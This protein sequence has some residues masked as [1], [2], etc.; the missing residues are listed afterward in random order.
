LEGLALMGRPRRG[1]LK[2]RP[3]QQGISYG[4]AFTYRGE[5][6]YEHFGGEWEGWDEERAAEEQRFLMEKVNRGQWTP[7][8]AES[9]RGLATATSPT[10]Q[11]EASQWL[12]RRK[13]RA[14]DLDGRTKTIRDL[15]GRL[16]VVMDKFGPAPIDE[17]DFGLADELVIELCEERSAIERAAA[18]GVPLMRLSATR[19]PEPATRP[20]GGA[21]PTD[22]FARHSMLPSAC[23]A[24]RRSG[25]CS[26]ARYPR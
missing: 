4:V 14:G 24:K 7:A 6:F 19:A 18:E 17:L 9:A 16:S 3:T 13:V 22:R 2:R 25:A 23:C 8:K 21:C 12:H 20:V 26:S 15:E 1:T 5:E 10:F 11:V